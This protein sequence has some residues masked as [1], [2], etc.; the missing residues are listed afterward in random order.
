MSPR[1]LISAMLLLA[2]IATATPSWSMPADLERLRTQR[3]LRVAVVDMDIAPFVFRMNGELRGADVDLARGFA[4][5]IGLEAVFVPVG[6]TYS[7][8]VRA[9][10]E[11][12]ADIGISELSKTMERAQTVLFSRPYFISG[13]T[14]V[15]NRLSEARL[16]GLR[17]RDGREADKGGREDLPGLLNDPRHVVAAMGGSIQDQ[18]MLTFF[19]SAVLRTTKTWHQ[20]A[21]LVVAGKVDA[22]IVPDRVHRLMVH[23]NPETD[24][25]A[26]AVPLLADPLVIAVHPGAPD[27]L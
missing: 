5:S 25:K 9:V 7:Q 15:V 19:P 17:P 21:E 22:A 11:G 3:T 16:R 12:H 20:A 1:C 27:L 2:S 23:Q 4:Q 24:Y 18:L 14:L 13:I 10:A 26:R 6:D 8:V